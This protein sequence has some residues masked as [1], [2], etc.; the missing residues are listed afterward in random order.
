AEVDQG[1]GVGNAHGLAGFPSGEAYKLGK[2]Q[3]YS[4]IQRL[5][6]RQTIALGGEST[7]V[8]AA[9]NQM[10]GTQTANRLV[11]TL[12][13]FSVVDVFDANQYAHDP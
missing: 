1:F 8:E 5:Y 13:K 11:I 10:A 2:A 7:P 9:A 12:G 6:L 4:R 3:P